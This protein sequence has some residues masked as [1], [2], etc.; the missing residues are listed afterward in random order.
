MLWMSVFPVPCGYIHVWQ[1]NEWIQ[2]VPKSPIGGHNHGLLC[3]WVTSSFTRCFL[4]RVEG[5]ALSYVYQM[6]RKPRWISVTT[7]A[8]ICTLH[9]IAS[10]APLSFSIFPFLSFFLKRREL[11]E[12]FC[13]PWEPGY[14]FTSSFIKWVINFPS[15]L[16]IAQEV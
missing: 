8:A 14:V 16:L 11:W 2:D 15:N 7:M 12:V 10:L 1:M 9:L 13:F 5:V 4:W 6:P 3:K